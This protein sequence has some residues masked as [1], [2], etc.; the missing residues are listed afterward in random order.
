VGG[1]NAHVIVEE[2]P[3]VQAAQGHAGWQVLALSARSSA[4][5]DG[6]KEKW[7]A[8]LAEPPPGFSL[9]DA[10]Y[11]TQAG[12][13]AFEHRCAIVAQDVDGVRA[14]LQV[15]SHG[16][17]AM[18]KAT[19]GEPGVVM[20]FPGGGAHYP[21]AGSELLTQ[22]AFA[23]AV[24]ECFRAMPQ[25]VPRDLRA[26]MFEGDPLDSQA[27]SKLQRPS[28]AMPALFTLEWALARAG[29]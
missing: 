29:A 20:M 2:P 25:E 28:Y 12:R 26:I 7:R 6:L 23:Q 24:D 1:T 18:G 22:P 8:F 4:S 19:A 16:R 14:A 9:A 10:A 5:L 27:A 3:V 15:K 17:C 21:G 13:R 11:T